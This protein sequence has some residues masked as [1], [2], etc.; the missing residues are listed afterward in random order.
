MWRE[1]DRAEGRRWVV[2]ME[3]ALDKWEVEITHLGLHLLSQ[4][5]IDIVI[6]WQ[7]LTIIAY[8]IT[9]TRYL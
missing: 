7:N 2:S 6:K 9:L 3:K 8:H 1:R 4:R 5:D